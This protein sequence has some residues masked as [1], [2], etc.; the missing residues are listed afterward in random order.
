M[1]MIESIVCATNCNPDSGTYVT[2]TG[3][4]I[5]MSVCPE[6]ATATYDECKG[7]SISGFLLGELILD[8]L[9]MMSMVV[10][11]VVKV[12]GVDNF[13]ITVAPGSCFTGA[14][15]TPSYTPCCDPLVVSPKCPAGA[16]DTVK[17]AAYIN[18]P[19]DTAACTAAAA[20]PPSAG[21][22]E[23]PSAA[24]APSTGSG[25][26]PSAAPAPSTGSGKPP[27]AGPPPSNDSVEPPSAPPAPST[28]GTSP[29]PAAPA[30]AE[31]TPSEAPPPESPSTSP[32]PAA[33]A[34][35]EGTPSEAPPPE[36]PS[37]SPALPSPAVPP[38]SPAI[39]S[40][41]PPPKSGAASPVSL[42]SVAAALVVG[43]AV[44]FV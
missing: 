26:P 14:T 8:P 15:P 18:R 27:G 11:N 36:S 34:P 40:P 29:S 16:V 39:P 20:P 32:S 44:M 33:P 41:P 9:A 31:G 24:P 19:I 5:I 13:N 12:M 28:G 22:G 2:K 38:P 37:T 17:Y 4:N 6:F 10:A 23:P 3:G 25:N 35:A 43:A 42:L 21:S 1:L 30:P 7:V